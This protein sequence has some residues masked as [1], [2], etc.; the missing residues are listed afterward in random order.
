MYLLFHGEAFFDTQKRVQG[1][2]DS[3]LS[4]KRTE[5]AYVS[6]LRQEPHS[7]VIKQLSLQTE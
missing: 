1:R 5:Q 2:V 3:P 7:F 6:K 4:E